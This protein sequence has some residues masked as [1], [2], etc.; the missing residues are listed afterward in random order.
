MMQLQMNKD[1]E[2]LSE[3]GKQATLC[4]MSIIMKTRE[5]D[6]THPNAVYG[7]A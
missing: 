5:T 7:T 2:L 4:L 6:K 3:D 1:I